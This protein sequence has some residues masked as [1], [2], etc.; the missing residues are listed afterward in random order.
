MRFLKRRSIRQYLCPSRPLHI[1]NFGGRANQPSKGWKFRSHQCDTRLKSQFRILILDRLTQCNGMEST[2]NFWLA[3]MHRKLYLGTDS[4]SNTSY[5]EKQSA[6][7]SITI[8]SCKIKNR[9]FSLE[10][11]LIY[12]YICL[13]GSR[14][15]VE[16]AQYADNHFGLIWMWSGLCHYLMSDPISDSSWILD[17]T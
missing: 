15:S 1:P 13:C 14:K 6:V 4:K 5:L 9:I 10:S 12:I 8:Q 17:V 2:L 3:K 7:A 11:H 16:A